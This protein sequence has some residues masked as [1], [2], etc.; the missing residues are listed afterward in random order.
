[1]YIDSI[2]SGYEM[3]EV[4]PDPLL[5]ASLEEKSLGELIGILSGYKKLHNK[6]DIDTKKKLLRNPIFAAVLLPGKR[7]GATI[8]CLRKIGC[9]PDANDQLGGMALDSAVMS[10]NAD[11]VAELLSCKEFK[12][13]AMP[14]GRTSAY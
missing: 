8:A 6:T 4:P 11:A 13:D 7:C 9:K 3:M 14:S 5:R 1:M 12:V 10:F 2:I